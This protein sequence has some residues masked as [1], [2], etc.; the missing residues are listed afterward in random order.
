MPHSDR[1]L[2]EA[3]KVQLKRFG[4]DGK[5]AF[6]EPFH[7]PKSDGTPG[8][9]VNKVKLCEPST[10]NVSVHNG[11]GV[12]DNDSMIRIDVFHV[13]N[14]G[15]YFVP[16]YVADTLKP[17]LPCKACVAHKPYSGW[18]AMRNEDFIFSLYPNDLIKIVHKS[19]INM[20][21]K[22]KDSTLAPQTVKE[23]MFYYTAANISS[24]AIALKTHDGAYEAHL[25]IKTLEKV[26]KFTV[27][28]LGEYHKI[29]KETRQP[30][31]RKRG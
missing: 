8:P 16:I 20:T 5:K 1:L 2:Y 27:D 15:Y 31:K 21:P 3:L 30:F 19:G 23:Q 14:D 6:T 28:V 7:K 4:G 24:G 10:L 22:N 29:D 9:V 12:A 13:E 26:E 17:E 18:K 11:M 25:G